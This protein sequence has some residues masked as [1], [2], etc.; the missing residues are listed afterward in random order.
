MSTFT[1]EDIRLLEKTQSIKERMI[2]NLMAVG[3]ELPVKP[4]DIDSYTNLLESVER[5][6]L[7]RAKISID[8]A[9]TKIQEGT[10]EVLTELL[11]SLHGG[12][13]P[14]LQEHPENAEQI[15][16]YSPK[17]MEV[18]QGSLI[19]RLDDVN[20]GDVVEQ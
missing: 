1:E 19:P 4:R 20:L 9:G 2:D 13:M 15:P 17:G 10:K 8:E 11:L 18:S 5:G 7:G 14:A 16:V 6:I 3:K 12:A